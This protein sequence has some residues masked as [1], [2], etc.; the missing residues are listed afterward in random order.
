MRRSCINKEMVDQVSALAQIATL[1]G[2][3]AHQT[4]LVSHLLKSLGPHDRRGTSRDE[5]ECNDAEATPSKQSVL[6]Q[7]VHANDASND[8]KEMPL[9]RT[10]C[11][12]SASRIGKLYLIGSFARAW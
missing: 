9:Q 3:I 11:R 4:S 10:P 12:Q 1:T 6:A 8:W 7:Q 2:R 5:V